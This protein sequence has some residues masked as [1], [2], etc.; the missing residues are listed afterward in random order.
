MNIKPKI[1]ELHAKVEWELGRIST[2]PVCFRVDD[3]A[4][5]EPSELV[6]LRFD[7]W[8][9]INININVDVN[10]DVKINIKIDT[11]NSGQVEKKCAHEKRMPGN[12]WCISFLT[13]FT[14]VSIFGFC[15]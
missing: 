8:A 14:G 1:K 10:V 9:D 12:S 2:P 3:W 11:R 15:K 13:D 5:S 6:G 4:V 7:G